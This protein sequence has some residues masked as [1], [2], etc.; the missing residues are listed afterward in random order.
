MPSRQYFRP[1]PALAG[2]LALTACEHPL[3][4][5]SGV[6]PRAEAVASPATT[7]DIAALQRVVAALAA[8]PATASAASQA[9]AGL[10]EAKSFAQRLDARFWAG[11]DA[12]VPSQPARSVPRR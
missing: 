4:L 7:V 3:D 6:S 8:E 2:L 12:N 10:P 1:V 5:P 9:M 11:F